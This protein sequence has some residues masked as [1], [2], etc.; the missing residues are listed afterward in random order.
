MVSEK[1]SRDRGPVVAGLTSA[2]VL[3]AALA[4]VLFGL[5]AFTFD[6]ADGLSYLSSDPAACANCHIMQTQ[7][8]SWQRASHR[9]V[10]GCVDCHL[11]HRGLGKWIAKADNG[12]RHSKAFTLQDFREPIGMTEGNRRILQR[13]CLECH[14][15]L[16]HQMAAG[17][18]SSVECVHCHRSVGHGE[19]A[20]LG[21]PNRS[22]SFQPEGVGP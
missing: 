13:N 12:Y 15:E 10:A 3:T 17:D 14:R 21:G 1:E 18:P 7:Y 19:R 2:V 5:G 9:N 11:P 6:Y 16:T 4:G 20:A 8:D 22:A